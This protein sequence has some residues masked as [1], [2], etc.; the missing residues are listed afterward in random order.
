M[1]C[2]FF[3]YNCSLRYSDVDN[4]RGNVELCCSLVNVTAERGI[5]KL[6]F[7]KCLSVILTHMRPTIFEVFSIY[8]LSMPFCVI[9]SFEIVLGLLDLSIC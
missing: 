9:S 8:S 1:V 4:V 5:K 7:A 2:L 6:S 3:S